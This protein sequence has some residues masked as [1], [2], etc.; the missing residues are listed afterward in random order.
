MRYGHKL[1]DTRQYSDHVFT[2]LQLGPIHVL[3]CGL[4]FG[5]TKN[6]WTNLKTS[7]KTCSTEF[8][9]HRRSLLSCSP[10]RSPLSFSPRYLQRT[11]FIRC[12]SWQAPRKVVDV[13]HT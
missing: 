10:I 5:G 4:Q 2:V 11:T 8:G 12:K 9:H 3:R 6:A 7:L 13:L 1:A